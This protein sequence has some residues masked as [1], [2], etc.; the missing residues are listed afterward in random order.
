[1]K[2]P[3][4]VQIEAQERLRDQQTDLETL[5]A[6]EGTILTLRLLQAL[7]TDFRQY[8]KSRK[9]VDCSGSDH[10]NHQTRG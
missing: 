5:H 4:A 1:M 6:I 7:E 9:A 10:P 2:V 3:L 8:M